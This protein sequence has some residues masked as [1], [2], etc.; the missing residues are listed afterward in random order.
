M[1]FFVQVGIISPILDYKQIFYHL[2]EY[3]IVVLLF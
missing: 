2:W 1:K 3:G